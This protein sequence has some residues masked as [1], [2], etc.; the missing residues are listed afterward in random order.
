MSHRLILRVKNIVVSAEAGRTVDFEELALLDERFQFEPESFPGAIGAATDPK[1]TYI[2][3]KSGKVTIVG[4]RRFAD[5]ERAVAVIGKV[6]EAEHPPPYK[7]VNC[8]VTGDLGCTVNAELFLKSVES[9]EFQYDFEQPRSL[10]Y[11]DPQTKKA[12]LLSRKGRI[13][14]VGANSPKLIKELVE[15]FLRGFGQRLAETAGT[16]QLNLP[17]A[18]VEVSDEADG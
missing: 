1:C 14:V 10:V 12:I 7:I 13:T 3:F 4:I 5:V 9:K 16:A 6:L 17:N 8:V 18:V 11:R 15:R 2:I